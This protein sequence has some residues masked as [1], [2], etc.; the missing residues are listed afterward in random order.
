MSSQLQQLCQILLDC[1]ISGVPEQGVWSA[2]DYLTRRGLPYK[3]AVDAVVL[4]DQGMLGRRGGFA[5]MWYRNMISH[6]K[7][8]EEAW[9]AVMADILISGCEL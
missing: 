5:L 6:G 3:M 7:S 2:F 1:I 4:I 8:H 9:C